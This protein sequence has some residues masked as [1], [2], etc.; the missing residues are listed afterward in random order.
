MN[1]IV[2]EFSRIVQISRLS[3]NGIEEDFKAKPAERSA[4]AKRFDL[5][6]LT[7]LEAELVLK[8]DNDQTISVTG[9]I[10]ADITQCCVVT[11]E[12]VSTHLNFP[13][14]VILLP[15]KLREAGEDFSL[16]DELDSEVEFFSGDKI[17]LGELVAQQLGVAIDPYPRKQNAVLKETEFGAKI[18]KPRPMGVLAE[19][20]QKKKEK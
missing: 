1:E 5:L 6:E 12:P 8:P 17:D 3:P 4:L 7:L 18:E 19:A 13:V 14:D 16:K 11:L 10:D 9:T 20:F 15:E 2:P